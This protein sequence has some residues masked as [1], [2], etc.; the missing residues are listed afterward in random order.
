[1]FAIIDIETTGGNPQRD[2]ITEVALYLHDGTRVVE[3]FVSLVNPE[4]SIPPFITRMT[5][6]SNEMVAGAPRFFEIARS[7]VTLT[8][9]AVFVAHNVSFDY[10]FIKN[11][12]K[13]LGYDYRREQLCTVKLSR[14]LMPGKAS[15]SL[16]RLCQELG[17]PI[18][19]RHRAAG[20]AMAT[21]Q[22]FEMLI[23][24]KPADMFL[25][26]L[27][28][29]AGFAFAHPH[30]TRDLLNGLPE[31]TG[32]Y[33]FR[34]EAGDVIYVGK[35]KDIRQRVLSHFLRNGQK[36]SNEMIAQTASIDF[37]IT[38]SELIALLRESEEVKQLKPRF[39]RALRQN[40][41][42]F[43]LYS[44]E[45]EKGYLCLKVVKASEN[46]HLP[47]TRFANMEK[48]KAFLFSLIERF[49]LCQNLCGLYATSG[50]CF[51]HAVGI[52]RGACCGKE[53]AADYNARV[54]KALGIVSYEHP[55]F[56]VVD[57][58]RHEE[59]KSLVWVED[60]RYVG[61]GF[62]DI[63]QGI[64]EL[65]HLREFVTEYDDN[66]DVQQILSGYLRNKKV[67]KLIPF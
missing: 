28:S 24:E 36:K 60:G 20:D 65:S 27:G 14:K 26:T 5:G 61:Y 2:R 7:L 12:F 13:R 23:Q 11:E 53:K 9:G 62:F 40:E 35:S 39:N 34:N 49:E 56:V 3:E 37:E 66:R 42:P 41:F 55:S 48:G 6:I 19:G 64:S 52:C 63:H 54:Q 21:V 45:D 50:A 51:Q 44:Y 30:I 57:K 67:E 43:G 38:G 17:I 15:Y 29:K 46:G 59:E 16:G 4:C 58:G 31:K 10:N 22:L 1:M 8:E 33:Y 47:H 25:E 32:V 18:N